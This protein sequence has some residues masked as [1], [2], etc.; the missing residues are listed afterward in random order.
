MRKG[1]FGGVLG[2][3]LAG[4]LVSSSVLAYTIDDNSVSYERDSR[5]QTYFGYQDVIGDPS[6]YSVTGI[7]VSLVNG[8]IHLELYTNVNYVNTFSETVTDNTGT[9]S[10]KD[11]TYSLADLAIGAPGGT[12]TY[13]LVLSDHGSFSVGLYKV[14][15]WVT[16]DELNLESGFDTGN[17]S[18]AS[19]VRYGSL[20][21][22]NN[23]WEEALV[24]IGD[25]TSE[26]SVDVTRQSLLDGTYVYT[27]EFDDALLNDLGTE[28]EIFWAGA[29]CGNDAIRG[30]AVVPEPSTLALLGFGLIGLWR[31]AGNKRK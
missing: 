4:L 20:Y 5:N 19:G 10:S 25:G 23:R 17:V 27:V 31:V 28:L 1:L 2:G 6:H 18:K 11:Y 12:F 29:T 3:V 15:D 30:T 21:D 9:E 8:N 13:G 22:Y 24:A 7:N 26:S 16:A 14:T